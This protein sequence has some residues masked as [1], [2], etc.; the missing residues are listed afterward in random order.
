MTTPTTKPTIGE[1]P[2]EDIPWDNPM[3]SLPRTAVRVKDIDVRPDLLRGS[4]DDRRPCVLI[5]VGGT[6]RR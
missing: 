5:I 1:S 3:E 2:D 4:C 6:I